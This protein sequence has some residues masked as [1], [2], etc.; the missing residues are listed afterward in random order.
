MY[1]RLMALNQVKSPLQIVELDCIED[2]YKCPI[3]QS[4][5]LIKENIE[6]SKTHA[7]N[8]KKVLLKLEKYKP[9]MNSRSKEEI[10]LHEKIRIAEEYAAFAIDTQ[11]LLAS[12]STY[13]IQKILN[14]AKDIYKMPENELINKF[15]S[16]IADEHLLFKKSTGQSPIEITR[17]RILARKENIT[18]KLLNHINLTEQNRR[19]L[20]KLE[21]DDM[22][23]VAWFLSDILD[24][25]YIESWENYTSEQLNYIIR[26]AAMLNTR[27]VLD[28]PEL[29]RQLPNIECWI[30]ELCDVGSDL[31][32]YAG[33]KLLNYIKEHSA[34]YPKTAEE[35]NQLF[36]SVFITPLNSVMEDVFKERDEKKL[37]KLPNDTTEKAKIIMT[38]LYIDWISNIQS[39]KYADEERNT[40]KCIFDS[41][42]EVYPAIIAAVITW[43]ESQVFSPVFRLVDVD[44]LDIL[45]I[46]ELDDQLNDTKSNIFNMFTDDSYEIA[47][48]LNYPFELLLP[49]VKKVKLMQKIIPSRKAKS[50]EIFYK[51]QK[52]NIIIESRREY[53]KNQSNELK[54]NINHQ[55]DNNQRSN[56]YQ[57]SISMNYENGS[58]EGTMNEFD[59]INNAEFQV[60]TADSVPIFQDDSDLLLS[61]PEPEQFVVESTPI[62]LV[63]HH[64]D[65]DVGDH[66]NNSREHHLGSSEL[67]TA[68]GFDPKLP[69]WDIKLQWKTH[70]DNLS[71]DYT[72]RKYFKI[73]MNRSPTLFYRSNYFAWPFTEAKDIPSQFT[74]VTE[75]IEEE[76]TELIKKIL[77]VIKKI[78]IEQM[79][80]NH[81]QHVIEMIYDELFNMING[82]QIKR[83]A[84]HILKDYGYIKAVDQKIIT[85][86]NNVS[87][88]LK[89]YN[90]L[91]KDKTLKE[92]QLINIYKEK[93]ARM[94]ASILNKASMDAWNEAKN[95]DKNQTTK[96]STQEE[97]SSFYTMKNKTYGAYKEHI[98]NR[99]S[100]DWVEGCSR[101]VSTILQ[102]VLHGKVA[103][104]G[105]RARSGLRS[106]AD[107]KE[108]KRPKRKLLVIMPCGHL[109]CYVCATHHQNTQHLGRNRSINLDIAR[110][111]YPLTNHTTCILCRQKTKSYEYTTILEDD[112]DL[113]VESGQKYTLWNALFRYVGHIPL[114]IIDKDSTLV[115]S[116]VYEKD[117]L[118]RKLVYV[119][120]RQFSKGCERT[121]LFIERWKDIMKLKEKKNPKNTDSNP[122]SNSDNLKIVDDNNRVLAI[123]DYN[124]RVLP[125]RD[126]NGPGLRI[127][128]A[129]SNPLLQDYDYKKENCNCIKQLTADCECS[130][131]L[132]EYYDG[133]IYNPNPV[134]EFYLYNRMQVGVARESELYY[135]WKIS[136]KNSQA[137]MAKLLALFDSSLEEKQEVPQ[138]I[139]DDLNASDRFIQEILSEET[140][141]RETTQFL[142]EI[143]TY[144]NIP[145]VV[146]KPAKMSKTQ[147]LSCSADISDHYITPPVVDTQR[148]ETIVPG[149]IMRI[150]RKNYHIN[151]RNTS[152]KNVDDEEYMYNDI[153]SSCDSDYKE[154]KEAEEAAY[155]EKQNEVYN[156]LLIEDPSTDELIGPDKE[157][158]RYKNL[159]E[160]K[161]REII[162]DELNNYIPL[163]ELENSKFNSKFYS[164]YSETLNKIDKINAL[165][166]P[167]MHDEVKTLINSILIVVIDLLTKSR[168]ITYLVDDPTIF[169]VNHAVSIYNS[170]KSKDDLNKIS[171]EK[172]L[173][174]VIESMQRK[175]L[176][177][178]YQSILGMFYMELDSEIESAL[179]KEG[180]KLNEYRKKYKKQYKKYINKQRR[181]ELYTGMLP[182]LKDGILKS[183]ET[184]EIS[185]R[186]FSIKNIFQ[187]NDDECIKNNSALVN[188]DDHIFN[189]QKRVKPQKDIKASSKEN[190]YTMK[191]N[192]I[193]SNFFNSNRVLCVFNENR[194][195]IFYGANSNW[196]PYLFDDIFLHTHDDQPAAT[197]Q[198]S[199]SN[200]ED[201]S[202]FTC[203]IM[204]YEQ[205]F[206]PLRF[207]PFSS[208]SKSKD[209]KEKKKESLLEETKNQLIGMGINVQLL[210]PDFNLVNT[211]IKRWKEKFY[212]SN[213]YTREEKLVLLRQLRIFILTQAQKDIHNFSYYLRVAFNLFK[214]KIAIKKCLEEFNT[215]L[216]QIESEREYS[217]EEK[218]DFSNKYEKALETLINQ[219]W[220]FRK[221]I[222]EKGKKL[223][224]YAGIENIKKWEFIIRMTKSSI[225]SRLNNNRLEMEKNTPKY[226][227]NQVRGLL[228][229]TTIIRNT[230]IQEL[231]SQ[232][233]DENPITD[234]STDA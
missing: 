60:N 7:E 72:I 98:K 48:K 206:K 24:D 62:S 87:V 196:G 92:Q 160:S 130:S 97:K 82:N 145:P 169:D 203:G 176:E 109:L 9:S 184:S 155:R 38:N 71:I 147:N 143:P 175:N 158:E 150:A 221:I 191:I 138:R 126:Y 234:S 50:D 17:S 119:D 134:Y 73:L 69:G 156:E 79:M 115:R 230:S 179:I 178:L 139:K 131:S 199:T 197:S 12:L 188:M 132:F 186:L 1:T 67:N 56:S 80:F 171:H 214:N 187:S 70:V 159:L 39:G 49:R 128:N 58:Y 167:S 195:C 229:E 144:S 219:S 208:S 47:K 52:L 44:K 166:S 27:K 162:A 13:D 198:A 85:N 74:T 63:E 103:Y 90:R 59:G 232:A 190:S 107:K 193:L 99:P 163:K 211:Y 177:I 31:A 6:I 106:S 136:T 14:L 57:G 124:G 135:P 104:N 15:N 113:A 182:A 217:Q 114:N 116:H 152:E 83:L 46:K 25:N 141:H 215:I 209:E 202:A 96:P 89:E 88:A 194:S 68:D 127:A 11:N 213:S 76:Y 170:D 108:Q 146:I 65:N 8:L 180:L 61:M 153:S 212:R 64:S 164:E 4:S 189:I 45:D 207:Y 185:I 204:A 233:V 140:D 154:E 223:G 36:T 226:I 26:E 121:N 66:W 137:R 111:E 183:M 225:N 91:M 201:K 77:V 200:P 19:K 40:D 43:M 161:Q 129:G 54:S 112:Y 22:W 172:V 23:E 95:T 151:S 81:N 118:D 125:I 174:I 5:S 53:S 148:K 165:E 37:L 142:I 168:R 33:K 117:A 100:A 16:T 18:K 218:D 102:N 84:K 28:M 110:S 120:G 227:I 21:I 93:T 228:R 20:E 123:R 216:N 35:Q 94:L 41:V 231:L 86:L 157:I 2:S 42:K 173:D 10:S 205:L 105:L 78:Q 149:V 224:S 220:V 222:T 55:H 133:V 29:N 122:E 75:D 101:D 192:N 3:C 32:F 34:E 51:I 210:N 30:G 181:N